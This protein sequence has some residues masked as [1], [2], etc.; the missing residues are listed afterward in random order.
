MSKKWKRL[1]SSLASAEGRDF[2]RAALPFI[3][4]IW[5]DAILPKPLRK[6]DKS[7][8]DILRWREKDGPNIP[9]AIQ[10]K[11][12][13]VTETELGKSQVDQCIKSIQTFI[14]SQ[15]H[16]DRY[17]L[18]HNRTPDSGFQKAIS[19]E[20]E[21][22]VAT[23]RVKEAAVWGYQK[24]TQEASKA[25]RKRIEKHLAFTS[26]DSD[27]VAFDH[28]LCAPLEKVPI[29]ITEVI[30]NSNKKVAEFP[31]V[32]MIADPA[33][34]L[35][36]TEEADRSGR[37]ETKN[38]SLVLARAGYGKTTTALRVASISP[39]RIFFLSAATLP[40]ETHNTIS[41]LNPLVQSKLD[42]LWG[43]VSAE[44]FAVVNQLVSPEL[45]LV[46]RDGQTKVV[47][48][49]DALDE[50]IYFSRKSGLQDLLNQVKEFKVPI[51]LLAR[52]EFWSEKQE[53]FEREV[54]LTAQRADRKGLGFVK[55]KLLRLEDWGKEQIRE[56][57]IRYRDSLSGTERSNLEG[58]IRIVESGDY[59]SI[60]GDIP[61][62]PLFLNYILE[63]VANEGVKSKGR[64][65]LFYDWVKLKIRR[66]VRNPLRAGGDRPSLLRTTDL[67]EGEIV[68]LS[69]LAMKIAASKM[70]LV[71]EDRVD[72][73]PTCS[74]EDIRKADPR[75]AT[76]LDEI[77]LFLHSLLETESSSAESLQIRFSHRTYQE[78]F[79]ALYL[80]DNPDAFEKREIPEPVCNQL[81]DIVAEAI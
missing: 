71:S 2:E 67:G 50:S 53:Q 58:L 22:L 16:A 69:F 8:V 66:D 65:R 52:E 46:L 42:T 57:A 28:P 74:A 14:K 61:K 26:S 6:F 7:G 77:S 39:R 17:I 29:S 27:I 35:L 12:F 63:S 18:V 72:L 44:D 76:H 30:A 11:G 24:L 4:A 34:E 79:L 81:K 1:Q 3:R 37:T 48:I 10:C 47:L 33:L 78:F 38:I 31:S 20:L 45:K 32:Q 19:E 40:K 5:G 64:A 80:R 43:E 36:R 73:L 60:Y 51:I 21:L 25:L 70:V 68:R 49:I 55:F 54:G 9:V 13:E 23:G 56:Y 41:L 62:R 75:F 15:F 59:E